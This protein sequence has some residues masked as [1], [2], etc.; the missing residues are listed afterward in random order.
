M[1]TFARLR[2][3]FERT[4]A[5]LT[6]RPT[7]LARLSK[8]PGVVLTQINREAQLTSSLCMHVSL[9]LLYIKRKNKQNR[10]HMQH[11]VINIA[12]R[13]VTLISV[14]QEPAGTNLLRVPRPLYLVE[15]IIFRLPV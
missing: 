14:I 1:F 13:T 5:R 6:D 2:I 3:K 9:Q 10:I 7:Q 8:L 4:I 12:R 15:R 11:I